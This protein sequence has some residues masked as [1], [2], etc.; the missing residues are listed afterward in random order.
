MYEFRTAKKFACRC[1]KAFQPLGQTRLA[2]M[3]Y[4]AKI[5]ANH[6]QVERIVAD[7]DLLAQQR[8][9]T[10]WQLVGLCHHGSS[11]LLQDLGAR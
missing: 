2:K 11:S 5:S 3:P 8:Q 4:E 9:H 7:I 6:S 10:L 1:F